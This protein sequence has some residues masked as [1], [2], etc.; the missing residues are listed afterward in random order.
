MQRQLAL[1][2]ARGFTVLFVP[3]IHT[4]MLYSQPYVH[5]TSLG[6]VL[7]F[8][9]EGP[10]AQVFM[11]IM[12]IVFT[13]KNSYTHKQILKRSAI[14]LLAGYLLNALKFILPFTLGA[15]PMSVQHELQLTPGKEYMQLLLMGDILQFAAIALLIIHVFYRLRNY[16]FW[17]VMVAL[18]LIAAAPM[19]FDVDNHYPVELFSGN[20][21]QVFFPVV[22]WIIYPLIG[23]SIGYGLKRRPEKTVASCA[24]AGLTILAVGCVALHW[25]PRRSPIGFY[26][27]YSIESLLHVSIVLLTLWVWYKLAPLIERTSFFDLLRFC[28]E[29]IT[30]IYLFQWILICWL[31]PFT[32]YQSMTL[33]ESM[34]AL[35]W[36]SVV[37]FGFT[38][39]WNSYK[40]I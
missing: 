16:W 40:K 34:V 39:L 8:I 35:S 25:F 31:L 32:G 6:Y 12:G 27:P 29:N 3:A 22:S 11:T 2:G 18:L 33:T 36:I 7:T 9:A 30:V 37:V 24:I 26:R 13:F 17:S 20:P 5:T 23:L 14:L 4:V 38:H 28:S 21:P 19:L 10:G 1:D 15:L